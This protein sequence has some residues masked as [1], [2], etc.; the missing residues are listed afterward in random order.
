MEACAAAL[1]K[2]SFTALAIEVAFA[3]I[4]AFATSSSFAAFTEA[5]PSFEAASFA[6]GQPSIAYVEDFPSFKAAFMTV[7]PLTA[8]AAFAAL[9]A[10]IPSSSMAA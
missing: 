6:V 10:T 3:F 1:P 4:S 8:S 5:Y 9:A 2:D 7:N